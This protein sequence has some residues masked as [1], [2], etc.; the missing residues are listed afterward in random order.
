MHRQTGRWKKR[1]TH[2]KRHKKIN[3]MLNM[4]I[5]GGRRP[6]TLG[7]M[8]DFGTEVLWD[9]HVS[10]NTAEDNLEETASRLKF[11]SARNDK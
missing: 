11:R 9:R 2:S 1:Q 7:E 10:I 4:D 8:E 3:R 5:L 6:S